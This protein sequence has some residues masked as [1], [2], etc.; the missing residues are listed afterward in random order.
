MTFLIDQDGVIYEKDRGPKTADLATAMT[1][2]DPDKAWAEVS[3]SE[4]EAD[5]E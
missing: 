3:A 2:F 4:G 5:A 1:A